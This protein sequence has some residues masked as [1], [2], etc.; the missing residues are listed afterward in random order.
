M[1]ARHIP[2]ALTLVGAVLILI[3]VAL[4]YLGFSAAEETLDLPYRPDLLQVLLGGLGVG[5]IVLGGVVAI[6]RGTAATT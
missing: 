3:A 4:F 5:S 2:L 1:S 6:R